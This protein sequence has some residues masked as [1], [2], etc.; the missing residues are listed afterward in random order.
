MNILAIDI[1]GTHLKFRT[2]AQ[3]EPVKVK[4]GR[5]MTPERMMAAIREHAADWKY[6][7]VSIG[8]PG[9]VMYDKPLM[10]PANLGK[11]WVGF[12]YNAAFGHKPLRILND[13]AMQAVGSYKGGRMLFLGLGTGLGSAMVVEGVVQPMELAHLLWKKGKTY[14]EYLGERALKRDGL[15]KWLKNVGKAIEHFR[16]V[17]QYD[18]VV[19]GGGN[20]KLVEKLPGQVFIGSNENAFKGAFDLW[21]KTHKGQHHKMAAS[22]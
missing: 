16:L 10:D 15:K 17:L 18:Y 3:R 22:S 14:E 21:R 9:P 4:S 5:K 2:Q 19:L 6:E 1:G 20:A 8:Y 13:A 7:R 12:D 11:G